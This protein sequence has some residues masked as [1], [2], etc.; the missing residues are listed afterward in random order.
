MRGTIQ[1]GFGEPRDV[2]RVDEV[3]A[4]EIDDDGVLVRVRAASIH[5]GAV[6]GVRGL[7][8]VMRPMFKSFIAKSGVIGQNIAG[9]VESVG[10][11]VTGVAVGDEVFGSCKGA[12]AEYAATTPDALAPKPANLT[13]EQ[14]SAVG[15][16]A[17]TALQALRTH[18]QLREGQHVLVTGASG[19]VGTF[20]VQIA[21]AT[22]AEVTGVCSTRNLDLVRSIGA[23]HVIDYTQQDF[24]TGDPAY[25]LILDN[26]GAHPLKDMRRVLTP[27]GLL[28]ANG[29]PAP[30]GWVGGLGHPLKVTVAS[31]FSRQ[32]G[33]PFL[34]MEN[35][36][37]LATLR[38]LAETGKITPVIDRVF[39]LD[40][41][42]EAIAYVGAGHNRGTSVITM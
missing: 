30:T 10:A 35:E 8:K 12:F 14:A 15:V 7:P 4:P 24:T 42:V 13:F 38:E 3:P 27:D 41:A 1:T 32:Q 22:G 25:A 21:K 37:D 26:V 28:L 23:D 31:L 20:A 33:R 36:E 11:N 19:G 29:A 39:P 34:S 17:F 16:S 40:D 2:L 6:Y 9:V 18:G 5:I